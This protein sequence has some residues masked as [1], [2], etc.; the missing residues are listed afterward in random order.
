MQSKMR[1]SQELR[2][3]SSWRSPGDS[4]NAFLGIV[5]GDGAWASQKDRGCFVT[6]SIL[7]SWFLDIVKCI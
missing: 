1:I 4:N 3:D 5:F 2:I 6:R 7:L